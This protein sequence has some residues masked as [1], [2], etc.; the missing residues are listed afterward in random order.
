MTNSNDNLENDINSENESLLPKDHSNMINNQSDNIDSMNE[1]YSVND[2][3][4]KPNSKTQNNLANIWANNPYTKESTAEEVL[5]KAKKR[6]RWGFLDILLS[7]ITMIA[8]SVVVLIPVA[9]FEIS[10]F[11]EE[12]GNAITTLLTEQQTKELTKNMMSNPF[13]LVGSMVSMYLAWWGFAALATYR[14]G[15][16]SFAKDFWLRF[17]KKD[18]LIGLA[19]GAGLLVFANS[20]MWLIESL[21]VNIEGTDNSTMYGNFDHVWRFVITILFVSIIGPISEELFFRGMLMQAFIRLFRRG[22][23]K[24][25]GS[26]S[27][28]A[29]LGATAYAYMGFR[30]LLYKHKYILAAILSSIAFGAMHNQMTGNFGD[31][32]LMFMTGTLGF[33]FALVTIKTR[34]LGPAII[35]HITFNAFT[36][37]QLFMSGF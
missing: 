36:G 7:V 31:I 32:V 26:A 35:A 3:A 19:V 12:N 22:N 16:K 23:I 30:R 18:I 34:R 33:V 13:L 4:N 8:L 14:A 29:S 27:L 24:N 20:F 10:K 28:E 9:Y 21:G 1:H 5:R 2:N 11:V 17:K 37:I 25:L 6:R 15:L